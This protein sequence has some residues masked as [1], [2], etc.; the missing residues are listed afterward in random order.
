[1]QPRAG[2]YAAIDSSRFVM[3][4]FQFYNIQLVLK[5]AEDF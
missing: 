4:L 5:I 3:D 1:M 2:E